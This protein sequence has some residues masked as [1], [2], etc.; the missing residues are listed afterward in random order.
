MKKPTFEEQQSAVIAQAIKIKG[1]RQTDEFAI[2]MNTF[3]ALKK[4]A[5]D[6]R[7]RVMRAQTTREMCLYMTGFEDGIQRC[8]DSIDKIVVD[9]EMAVELKEQMASLQ[10]A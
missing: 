7:I 1:L 9:G 4:I 8:V 10:E 6:E 2:L 5:S 3:N